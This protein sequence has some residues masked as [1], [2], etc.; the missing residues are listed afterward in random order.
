MSEARELVKSI[1]MAAKE[2]RSL[3]VRDAWWPLDA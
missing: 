3:T 2:S 1:S